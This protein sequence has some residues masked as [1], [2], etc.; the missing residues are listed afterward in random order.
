MAEDLQFEL[1]RATGNAGIEAFIEPLLDLEPEFHGSLCAN[2]D[3]GRRLARAALEMQT[4]DL[5]EP[6]ILTVDG[7]PAGLLVR[8]PCTELMFRQLATLKLAISLFGPLSSQQK[9]F[10]QS[11]GR[12][13]PPVPK[14]DVYISKFV[15]RDTFRGRGLGE[16]MLKLAIA[17]ASTTTAE[18]VLHIRRENSGARV[19][20]ERNGF[21]T[22]SRG[23]THDL[24]R[25]R[26]DD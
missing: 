18:F 17:S 22:V 3:E 13:V 9:E 24:M 2:R 7:E 16:R 15:V 1:A 6:E 23:I 12:G 26:I 19:F 11:W 14:R 20:Y 8:F 21:E 25:R 4:S 10:I 5:G